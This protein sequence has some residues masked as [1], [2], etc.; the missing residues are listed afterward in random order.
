MDRNKQLT[1]IGIE[2]MIFY[3]Y[4]PSSSGVTDTVLGVGDATDREVH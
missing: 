2:K 1:Q 3:E 4:Q